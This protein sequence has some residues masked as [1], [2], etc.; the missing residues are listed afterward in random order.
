M[1]IFLSHRQAG[2]QLLAITALIL[3][4]PSMRCSELPPPRNAFTIDLTTDARIHL[5][6]RICVP[7]PPILRDDPVVLS[8]RLEETRR[9]VLLDPFQGWPRNP[10]FTIEPRGSI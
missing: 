4:A 6:P 3:L 8:L 5:T 9:K 1:R 2:A 7:P 10:A